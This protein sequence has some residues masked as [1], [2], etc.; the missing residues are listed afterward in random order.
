MQVISILFKKTVTFI[1]DVIIFFSLLELAYYI[2]MGKSLDFI[3]IKNIISFNVKYVIFL[4]FIFLLFI[5]IRFLLSKIKTVYKYA[6][7]FI[8]MVLLVETNA[9]SDFLYTMKAV[10][11]LYWHEGKIVNQS[12]VKYK[13]IAHAG[14][15]LE[16]FTYLNCLESLDHSYKKGFKLIELDIQKT[17]DGYFVAVHDW[18]SWRKMTNYKGDSLP[19]LKEFLAHR[20]YNKY[21]PL[22]MHAIN[23]WFSKHPDI[24]LVTDKIN[25][26]VKFADKFIDKD[27]LVMEL[28]TIES[29]IKAKEIGVTP[30]ASYN[31]LSL[32]DDPAQ[33]LIRLGVNEIVISYAAYSENIDL[34]KKIFK[35]GIHIY[36]YGNYD[37]NIEEPYYFGRYLNHL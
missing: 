34:I 23:N 21:T 37:K 22:D 33:D 20:L 18:N 10:K 16:G 7:A 11:I 13:L 2:K 1:V 30:M 12:H 28:F 5:F 35:V 26:P 29:I 31:L 24:I 32:L 27:R 3:F 4:V 8:S 36:V 15:E 19:T 17:G 9:L 25:S 14:G 6:A